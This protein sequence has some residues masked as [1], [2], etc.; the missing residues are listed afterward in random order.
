MRKKKLHKAVKNLPSEKQIYA[1]N[2]VS[3]FKP[4]NAR[5]FA[6]LYWPD[7][8]RHLKR[9]TNK[10]SK[11]RSGLQRSG[12]AVL[13]SLERRNYIAFTEGYYDITPVGKRLLMDLEHALD[14]KKEPEYVIEQLTTRQLLMRI[15]SDLLEYKQIE[16]A[17]ALSH[18][19][20]DCD[21][22]TAYKFLEMPRKDWESI[23]EPFGRRLVELYIKMNFKKKKAS[24]DEIFLKDNLVKTVRIRFPK[25]GRN[26]EN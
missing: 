18:G 17:L 12:G 20:E 4:V 26:N 14:V 13:K 2:I 11:H 25:G 7:D 19:F 15:N 16:S 1:I 21:K 8:E 23:S 22:A 10:K 24:I 5:A 3:R 9:V 6:R